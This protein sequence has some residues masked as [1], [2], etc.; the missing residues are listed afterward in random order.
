MSLLLRDCDELFN[1]CPDFA[2]TMRRRDPEI[3]VIVHPE[4]PR[5][6]VELAD[7]AGSTSRIIQ[8]IDS[9]PAGSK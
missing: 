3:R 5:E 1:F 9:A 2:G 4:C 8:I 6:V 7:D